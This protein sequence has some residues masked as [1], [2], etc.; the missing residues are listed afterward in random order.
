[1][2]MDETL[3]RVQELAR[4]VCAV[5]EGDAWGEAERAL[6]LDWAVDAYILT[7]AAR[8]LA[9]LEGARR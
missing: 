3:E 7:A 8:G 9:Q 1:M 4:R 5:A 6:V 2:E